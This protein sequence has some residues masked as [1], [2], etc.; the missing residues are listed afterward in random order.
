MSEFE[1]ACRNPF[2]SRPSRVRIWLDGEKNPW[3][4][5]DFVKSAVCRAF[6]AVGRAWWDARSV[7][8]AQRVCIV[9][10]LHSRVVEVSPGLWG[11]EIPQGY[12]LVYIAD[13]VAQLAP[14]GYPPNVDYDLSEVE[15]ARVA[16]NMR[17]T[18]GRD[19]DLSPEDI[20]KI[21]RAFEAVYVNGFVNAQ[22]HFR[23][24]T[25]SCG[26]FTMGWWG[27]GKLRL[28][29]RF[30]E[31]SEVAAASTIIEELLHGYADIPHGGSPPVNEA[32]Y[33]QSYVMAHYLL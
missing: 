26:T 29:P 10:W 7:Y 17:M 11:I 18:F 30:F 13:G 5:V 32:D 1:V 20:D 16:E 14:K 31:G 2:D 24:S 15:R 3:C 6:T 19:G 8:C 22:T 4:N 33:Y 25:R 9:P 23:C 12:E 21:Y 28:C 27:A